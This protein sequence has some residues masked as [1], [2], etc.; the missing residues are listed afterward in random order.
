M[1]RLSLVC[2]MLLLVPIAALAQW[3]SMGPFGGNARS[4]AYDPANPDHIL[5][6]SGAGALFESVDGGS[7]W[8]PL[9]HLELGIDLMVKRI[10]FD[11]THPTTI[12]AAGWNVSG[13]GGGFFLTRDAGKTWK[14]PLALKGKSIQALAEAG[15]DPRILIAGALDGVYRSSDSG[16]NWERISPAGHPDLKNFE[17]VAIAPR[18][19]KIVYAGTWH[20]PWKTTDGGVTWNVIK[21]GVIDDSDVFSIILSHSTP[22]IVF[23]SACSGIYKSDDSGHLFH[24]VQGIPGTARRTRVLQQDPKDSMTVYAGTT[25]GLWKTTD[26]GKTFRRISPPDYILN[27][28]LVDPR[29]PKRVLIATDRGGVFA[30]DDAGVTFRPSND[31]FSERQISTVIAD[32]INSSDLYAAVLNDKEFGGV[33]HAHGGIWSQMSDGLGG[34]DVFD[35]GLSRRGQLVAGTNRG[36]FLFDGKEQS[37]LPYR[38]I[39]I[40]KATSRAH[41][42]RSTFEG[43]VWALALA[44]SHWYAATD[45]GVLH[46]EDEGTSW[47]VVPIE[48]AQSFFSVSAHDQV[49]AAAS[50]SEVWHSADSGQ[51]WTQ[52]RLP[53]E[54]TRVYSVTVTSD[55]EVW[56]STRAG[57]MRWIHEDGKGSWEHVFNG[58]PVREVTSIRENGG[59]FLATG[60]ASDTVYVS[61]DRGQSWKAVD[62]G[63]PFEVTGTAMQGDPPYLISRH[64]GVLVP[65]PNASA[66]DQH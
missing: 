8:R 26:G 1:K 32:P 58:L 29:E 5:L 38:N 3:R 51:H 41:G 15:S 7:H 43:R 44:D 28:I 20:L 53:S 22:E 39:P 63:A 56:A 36:L 35:L 60:A 2:A 33:F 9:A 18:D 25:E 55:G 50:V 66:A 42:G 49:V 14:E 54:V 40:V 27:D 64:H 65:E 34:R 62:P 48:K 16:E 45:A 57:A 21:H 47:T 13:V 52:L 61:R 11:P 24:K 59:V 30:S 4:L 31:G 17:S 10:I 23:A 37:W 46:S 19:P 6:G 12:Y